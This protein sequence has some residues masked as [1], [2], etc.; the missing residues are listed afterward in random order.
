MALSF[1]LSSSLVLSVGN[2][3]KNNGVLMQGT[4][5]PQDGPP[6]GL[7][8]RVA[9]MPILEDHRSRCFRQLYELKGHTFIFACYQ[10]VSGNVPA[11]C[12]GC[13]RVFSARNASA[14]G[15]GYV[16]RSPLGHRRIADLMGTGDTSLYWVCCRCFNEFR[17]HL[18]FSLD[19]EHHFDVILS[20][21]PAGRSVA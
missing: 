2:T 6:V 5:S 7:K 12:Y 4:G 17:V 3:P 15:A 13:S 10:K 14:A 18:S 9:T 8:R 20:G 1:I 19:T 11:T 16:T 21:S